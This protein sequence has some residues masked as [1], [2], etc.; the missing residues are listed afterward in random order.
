MFSSG[1]VY[2]WISQLQAGEETALAKL[3]ERYWPR[4]VGLARQRLKEVPGRYADEEDVA[5]EAFWSFY[6]CL[7]AGRPFRLASRH[8]LLA[9]LTHIIAWKAVN[10]IQHERGVQKRGGSRV[11][12]LSGLEGRGL[13]LGAGRLPVGR[14]SRPLA[15]SRNRTRLSMPPT[16]SVLLSGEK[17]RQK[18]SAEDLAR[19]WGAKPGLSSAGKRRSS[20]PVAVSQIRTV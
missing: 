6:R 5:Q 16:A 20:L 12:S 2:T 10:Q 7:K 17:A 3:R 8:D 15:T 4:L 11:V 14:I 13:E 19:T 1:S 18:N 9:L